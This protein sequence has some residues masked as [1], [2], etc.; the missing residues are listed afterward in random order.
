MAYLG[1][2]CAK[3]G[4]TVIVCTGRASLRR[5][6][7]G[8]REGAD[9]W[10]TKPMEFGELLIEPQ[11]CQARIGGHSMPAGDRSVDVFVGRIRQ[12]LERISAS[13]YIHTHF[14][15]GY[16]FE[17]PTPPRPILTSSEVDR[18]ATAPLS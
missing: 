8:L 13:G 12:K 11:F 17:P 1:R 9:E 2:L 18:A 6:L 15:F 16:R 14:G 10:I 5:R 3:P 4:L 7:R